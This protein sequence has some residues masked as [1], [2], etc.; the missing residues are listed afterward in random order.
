MIDPRLYIIPKRLS[1]IKKIIA[2]SGG[3]GGVGKSMISTLISLLL[4]ENGKKVGLL[5]MDFTSPSTHLILGEKNLPFPEEEKGIIPLNIH[6]I[7]YISIVSYT[8]DSPTPLRGDDITNAILELFAITR[9]GNIDYLILDL[10][11]G[12]SDVTLDLIRF[13]KNI[14]F[15]LVATPS[16]LSWGTFTKVAT[17]LKKQNVSIMGAIL[18]MANGFSYDFEKKIADTDIKYLGK[19][20]FYE[21]LEQY[22]G[23]P[24]KLIKSDIMKDLQNILG[25]LFFKTGHIG[26]SELI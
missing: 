17:L 9:W 18:N 11:P 8:Q 6:G 2:I 20:G 25:P 21:E 22:I 7:S 16:I 4:K 23:I 12:I 5:D 26:L 3:K 1:K 14:E 10:P 15:L 13:I 19:L 24:N